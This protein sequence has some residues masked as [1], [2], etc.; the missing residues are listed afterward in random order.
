M[1]A[2]LRV[3]GSEPRDSFSGMLRHYRRRAGL[4]LMALSALLG[5][6][7]SYMA[8]IESGDRN[9]PKRDY[10][11]LL[12][13]ALRLSAV[14]RSRF[15]VAAGH[16]PEGVDEIGW[17]DCLQAVLDILTDPYLTARQRESFALLVRLAA[18][19]WSPRSS[20]ARLEVR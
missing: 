7:H 4:N 13:D 15:L 2:A 6:N 12:A 3:Y 5:K 18:N 16:T 14:E 20:L 11:L 9:P 10:V 8:R 19:G 17:D 1:S